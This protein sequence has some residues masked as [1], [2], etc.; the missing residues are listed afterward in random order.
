M[1]VISPSHQCPH[2]GFFR[3]YMIFL[4]R[5]SMHFM[6]IKSQSPTGLYKMKDNSVDLMSFLSWKAT[7]YTDLCIFVFLKVFLLMDTNIVIKISAMYSENVV[8]FQA[9]EGRESKIQPLLTEET[10]TQCKQ[11]LMWEN[12][13]NWYPA[14]NVYHWKWKWK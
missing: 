5:T 13:L 4:P 8:C 11:S 6:N 7:Q 1:H 10:I 14:R 2:D 9:Y 3:W 12:H